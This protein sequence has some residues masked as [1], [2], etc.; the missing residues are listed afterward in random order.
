MK[1]APC[2]RGRRGGGAASPTVGTGFPLRMSS[3]RRTVSSP[4]SRIGCAMVV[5]GGSMCAAN[6]MSS[7][8]TTERSSGTRRV[9]RRAAPSAPIAISSLKQKIAVGG[10]GSREQPLAATDPDSIEKSPCM[11]TKSLLGLDRFGR[12]G[13]AAQAVAA[14]RADERS[15]DDA[16]AAMAERVQ[17]IHR[18]GGGRGVVDVHARDAELRAE[19]AAVDDRRAARRHRADQRGRCLPAGDGRGRSGRPLP[20]AA[21]SA[22]SVPRAPRRAACRRAAPHSPRA[23]R[24]LRCPGG[25]ARRTDWRCRAR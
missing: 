2:S 20:C 6:R 15:G 21:A 25:S 18:L 16:D 12:A 8:P 24:L 4:I 19:L 1:L 9:W 11:T 5:S 10:C 13:R 14:E 17:M 7:N 22:R 3:S 23:A